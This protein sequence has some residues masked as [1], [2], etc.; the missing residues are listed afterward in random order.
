MSKASRSARKPPQN[1]PIPQ[2]YLLAS[3]ILGLPRLARIVLVTL[4]TMAI[5]LAV[6]PLV[7]DIY[8]RYFFTHETRI[9]PSLV[10][11]GIGILFYI[12]GWWGL[13]G[14][15][16]TTLPV[17]PAVLWYVGVGVAAFVLVVLL[18]IFGY[19]TAVAPT[20]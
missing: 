15:V 18:L 10:S 8:L 5:I 16:G 11:L 1:T 7:D 17:R 6:F 12:L 13:V 20:F 19:S 9:L 2:G 4:L 3:R 14:M